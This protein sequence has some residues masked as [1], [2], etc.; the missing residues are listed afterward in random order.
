MKFRRLRITLLILPTL[1]SLLLSLLW[2]RSFQRID[3][4]RGFGLE[5]RSGYGTTMY[6]GRETPAG[7][8]FTSQA[9]D[10]LRRNQRAIEPSLRVRGG[11]RLGN[12]FW[13]AIPYWCLV[14]ISTTI[15]A[16]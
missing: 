4:V 12:H 16:I 15:A 7:L 6:L 1:A 5:F 9:V 8:R 14:A 3:I 13:I 2:T 10:E 11:G